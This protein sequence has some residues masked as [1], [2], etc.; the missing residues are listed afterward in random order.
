[1]RGIKRANPTRIWYRL[2]K[3]I[4]IAQKLGLV[5]PGDNA[6]SSSVTYCTEA[7]LAALT[8]HTQGAKLYVDPAGPRTDAGSNLGRLIILAMEVL[9]DPGMPRSVQIQLRQGC[10]LNSDQIRQLS[11]RPD[12]GTVANS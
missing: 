11:A 5:P 1:M 10:W 6:M 4:H 7:E 12:F 8:S 2:M 9:N 3:L